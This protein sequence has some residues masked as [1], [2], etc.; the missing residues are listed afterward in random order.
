MA[1]DEIVKLEAALDYFWNN[2]VVRPEYMFSPEGVYTKDGLI[3]WE[4]WDRR[5]APVV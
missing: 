4:E 1:T 5:Q 3:S 2:Y